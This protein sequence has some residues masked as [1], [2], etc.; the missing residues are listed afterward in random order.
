LDEPIFDDCGL[1]IFVLYQV[2]FGLES[3]FVICVVNIILNQV[4]MREEILFESVEIHAFF[5]SVE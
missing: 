1:S 2:P 3:S 5:S 4:E